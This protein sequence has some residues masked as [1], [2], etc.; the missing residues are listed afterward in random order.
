MNQ[1]FYNIASG[2]VHQIQSKKWTVISEVIVRGKRIK[3]SGNWSYL[4]FSVESSSF[5]PL[6]PV[7]LVTARD[8]PGL[9][10]SSDIIAFD[11]NW[12][13]LY[14]T[15]AGGDLS[16]DAQIRVIGPMEP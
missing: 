13:H 7:P 16:N 10:S 6:T 12:H 15:S 9:S 2:I 4:S 11:Q 1:L 14:S 3:Q 5:N 8:E